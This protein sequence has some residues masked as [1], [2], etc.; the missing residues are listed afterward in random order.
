MVVGCCAL[1]IELG[2]NTVQ[3]G[4]RHSN[5]ITTVY[6]RDSWLVLTVSDGRWGFGMHRL[7]NSSQN[8][9][10]KFL[11][12]NPSQACYRFPKQP[13]PRSGKI[14]QICA[15]LVPMD[16]FYLAWDIFWINI[17][18][19]ETVFDDQG[20]T[21]FLHRVQN[22]TNFR[23][24]L[25]QGP[26]KSIKFVQHWCQWIPFIWREI[27]FELIRD[28]VLQKK[29]MESR[30]SLSQIEKK[31][32]FP[33]AHRLFWCSFGWI[34]RW[35]YTVW[36]IGTGWTVTIG[37]KHSKSGIR[38]PKVTLSVLSQQ[39]S[40][41]STSAHSF[42]AQHPNGSWTRN[43]WYFWSERDL[44]SRMSLRSPVG[45]HRQILAMQ[46]TFRFSIHFPQHFAVRVATRTI[47]WI[48]WMENELTRF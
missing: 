4:R 21:E 3:D 20:K 45:D 19:P 31:I 11:A 29:L 22:I 5:L 26:S 10:S 46:T 9:K 30:S 12:R 27:F 41:F 42:S 35:K 13:A 2:E 25:G 32:V 34:L 47:F 8:A 6:F 48:I 18:T 33:N 23:N 44:W 36:S 17:S 39:I 24:S 43:M 1:C 15:T 16:T 38:Y 37:R 28:L 14:N 40:A 7:P